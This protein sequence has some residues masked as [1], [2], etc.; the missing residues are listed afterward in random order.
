MYDTISSVGERFPKTQN[1]S[2]FKGIVHTFTHPHVA[3]NPHDLLSSIDHKNTS[4]SS[5]PYSDSSDRICTMTLPYLIHALYFKCSEVIYVPCLRIGNCL[6]NMLKGIIHPKLNLLKCA[7]P[8]A[9]QDEDEF[10]SSSDLEKCSCSSM[11]ALQWMGAVRM[12]VD[13]NITIIH[14]S[15]VHRLTSEKIKAACSKETNPSLR[16]FNFKLSLL[17]SKYE[18][19]IHNKH[20]LEWKSPSAVVSHIKNQS[21]VCLELFWTV[22]L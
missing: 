10:V 11:D 21:H 5:F 13:K 8:Q 4:F 12:R 18:S 17:I 22:G 7:H 20:F 3:Q 14:T 15:P 1:A 9:I 6:F 16:R 19:I 2:G